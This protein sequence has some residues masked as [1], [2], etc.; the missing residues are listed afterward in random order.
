VQGEAILP[1]K[2]TVAQVLKKF[3]A[4]YGTGNYITS[5]TRPHHIANLFLKDS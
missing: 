2:L 5:V 1:E 3:P 4:F